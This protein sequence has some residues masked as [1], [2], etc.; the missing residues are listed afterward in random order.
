M[1]PREG[2]LSLFCFGVASIFSVLP[3][4]LLR[5]EFDVPVAYFRNIWLT[6]F[7][8]FA[9]LNVLLILSFR[10]F[11]YQVA[12]RAVFLGYTFGVGILVAIV[13]PS[14][15]QVFGAYVSVLSMFHYSE[16]LSIAWTNPAALSIDSFILNHS[17]AYG[18]AACSSW[19]EFIVER[20]YFPE[21]KEASFISY[22]GFILCISGEILRKLAMFTAKHNFNHIVQNEKTDDHELITHGVY[23]LCRHPSYVGWFYWSIGTQ[24]ILQNPFCLLAYA[25]T[26][27]RFFH[28]RVL[29]EE[30]ALLTFFGQDYVDY[31]KSVGT[32]LPFIGGYK[33]N[34]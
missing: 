22:I 16:F 4:I 21:W 13:A 1:L 19:I 33:M 26:S 9:F 2:K 3:E 32:G 11:L 12:V 7:F 6:H 28:D 30:I 18:V 27:W 15:W 29:I 17:V 20:Q 25:I 10:G 31:Q 24:L 23:K 8:Q 5:L 34:L 14:S